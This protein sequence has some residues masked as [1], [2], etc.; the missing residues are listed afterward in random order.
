ML[1]LTQTLHSDHWELHTKNAVSLLPSTSC[2]SISL[3]LSFIYRF[4]PPFLSPSLTGDSLHLSELRIVL[5]GGK[6][7]GK[8]SSGNTILG[9][10]EFDL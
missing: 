6:R 7:A 5:L 3:N 1:H 10:E 8:S 9:R 4:L 2:F